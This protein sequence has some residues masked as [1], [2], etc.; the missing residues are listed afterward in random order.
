MKYSNVYIE[1][2]GCEIAPVVVT[3]AELEER[4][5]DFTRPCTF[6]RGSL[7]R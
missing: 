2:I 5:A 6:R 7:R 4:L 3:S 1:S